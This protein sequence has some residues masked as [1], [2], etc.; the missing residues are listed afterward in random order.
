MRPNRKGLFLPFREIFFCSRFLQKSLSGLAGSVKVLNNK[1]Y[2]RQDIG[3]T[4]DRGCHIIRQ[5]LS[6]F[7]LYTVYFCVDVREDYQVLI[8]DQMVRKPFM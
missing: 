3:Q 2:F 4:S 5:S 8:D 6:L 1:E 7:I